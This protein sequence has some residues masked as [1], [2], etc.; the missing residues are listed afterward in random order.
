MRANQLDNTEEL[1]SSPKF[2]E[3]SEFTLRSKLQLLSQ[4]HTTETLSN[5]AFKRFSEQLKSSGKGKLDLWNS[6][7]VC[8][9]T[10]GRLH[11]ADELYRGLLEYHPTYL[12]AAV[13]RM[14]IATC[15]CSE[16][17][18]VNSGTQ[19]LLA[20]DTRHVDALNTFAV[21][22]LASGKYSQAIHILERILE[23]DASFTGARVNLA[24]AH[25]ALGQRVES[26]NILSQVRKC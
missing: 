20:Q 17:H 23:I 2:T 8:L 16:K 21:F 9:A 11:S 22:L 26:S 1:L 7:G 10:S 5:D 12:D 4:A 3:L 15:L 13:N 24:L 14:S 18:T 19:S 25:F 6:L